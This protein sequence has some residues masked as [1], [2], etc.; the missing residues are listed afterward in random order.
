MH[1]LSR[2]GGFLLRLFGGGRLLDVFQP[3]LK[4]IFRQRLGPP[5]EATAAD[6]P[7]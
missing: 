5:A 1:P 2:G 4:L 3:E 6:P 7:P